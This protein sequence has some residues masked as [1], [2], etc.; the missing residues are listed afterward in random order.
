MEKASDYVIQSD[1]ETIPV[2]RAGELKAL[3]ND[4]SDNTSVTCSCDM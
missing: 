1:R 2:G 3:M 4:V